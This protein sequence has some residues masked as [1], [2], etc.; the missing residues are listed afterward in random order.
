MSIAYQLYTLHQLWEPFCSPTLMH[1]QNIFHKGILLFLSCGRGR[2]S[3]PALVKLLV[4]DLSVLRDGCLHWNGSK[5][6]AE[7]A[8]FVRRLMK[9][10]CNSEIDGPFSPMWS[11]T[12]ESTIWSLISTS[13]DQVL[14][15][16]NLLQ[17]N[18]SDGK[19]SPANLWLLPHFAWTDQTN[20]TKYQTEIS[21]TSCS[22]MKYPSSHNRWMIFHS[23]SCSTLLCRRFFFPPW[24]ILL[25]GGN[26]FL[27]NCQ[28]IQNQ[29]GSSPSCRRVRRQFS[30]I[31]RYHALW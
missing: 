17:S 28:S 13:K 23:Q 8:Y 2:F 5:S 21:S 6:G 24:G 26:P 12:W 27:F 3:I 20:L 1:L 9:Y 10:P 7:H 19:D 30:Q 31:W 29:P 22:H 4:K 16:R 25:K 15:F 18:I 14:F 11:G